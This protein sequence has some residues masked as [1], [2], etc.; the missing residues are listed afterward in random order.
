M[1]SLILSS[2]ARSVLRSIAAGDVT[3]EGAQ[4]VS[5]GRTVTTTTHSLQRLG[6][7]SPGA[8]EG[9]PWQ[10]TAAGAAL[11]AAGLIDLTA[12]RVALLRAAGGERIVQ[13]P[14]GQLVRRG[15]GRQVTVAMRPLVDADLVHVTMRRPTSQ[16]WSHCLMVDL[17]DAGRA[18]VQAVIALEVAP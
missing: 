4:V 6:L 17:T 2:R 16:R 12:A 9:E 14:D 8:A 18:I 13:T 5:W 3:T 15:D 11:V 1:T 7:V 10:P